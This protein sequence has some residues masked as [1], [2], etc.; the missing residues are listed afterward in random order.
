MA[1]G[2]KRRGHRNH[3]AAA[4]MTGTAS[5]LHSVDTHPPN[6]HETAS[7]WSRRRVLLLN[8]TYE[9]LDRKSVV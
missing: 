8:S 6:R 3:G 1:Q 5:C 4:S 7:I 2:K 9:P